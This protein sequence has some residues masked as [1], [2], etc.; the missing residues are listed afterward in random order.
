MRV[1]SVYC[2]DSGPSG[3]A[4]RIHVISYFRDMYDTEPRAEILILLSSADIKYLYFLRWPRCMSSGKVIS[5]TK[6]I[7]YDFS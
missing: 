4:R 3:K 6:Y 7:D 2:Y 5:I 1:K